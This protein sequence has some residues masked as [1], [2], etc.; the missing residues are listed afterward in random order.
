MSIRKDRRTEG[1]RAV[2]ALAEADAFS[3]AEWRPPARFPDESRRIIP[4]WRRDDI[5]CFPST[6]PVNGSGGRLFMFIL[7]WRVNLRP[8]FADFRQSPTGRSIRQYPDGSFF[9]ALFPALSDAFFN[10]HV[11]KARPAVHEHGLTRTGK[12]ASSSSDAADAPACASSPG[13]SRSPYGY[14]DFKS[15]T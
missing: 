10:P 6:P 14:R 4:A 2:H 11:E 3:P 7:C 12:A 15:V 13:S 9:F 1:L 8:R 5:L